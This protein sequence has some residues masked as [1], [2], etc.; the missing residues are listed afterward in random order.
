MQVVCSVLFAA[1]N[2]LGEHEDILV[3]S[4]KH[5]LN[6]FFAKKADGARCN[7]LN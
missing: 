7:F 6:C 4:K 1:E 3:K 5:Q 2:V